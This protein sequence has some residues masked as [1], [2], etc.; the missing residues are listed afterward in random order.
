MGDLPFIIRSKPRNMMPEL[1]AAVTVL[2]S[3]SIS[4]RRS[5]SI[6]LKGS[7]AIRVAMHSPEGFA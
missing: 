4:I 2:S 3:T 7:I 6:L 1:F 5:P